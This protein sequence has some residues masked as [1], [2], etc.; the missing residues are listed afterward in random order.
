MAVFIRSVSAGSRLQLQ[1]VYLYLINSWNISMVVMFLLFSWM[2]LFW[3]KNSTSS[4][5]CVRVSRLFLKHTMSM[6]SDNDNKV[7]SSVQVLLAVRSLT[8]SPSA[9]YHLFCTSALV[10]C[11]IK[12]TYLLINEGLNSA[13]VDVF[14]AIGKAR[15]GFRITCSD[16]ADEYKLVFVAC[17]IEL[18]C[19]CNWCRDRYNRQLSTSR[20]RTNVSLR[21]FRYSDKLD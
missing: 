17:T 18:F 16:E 12:A 7:I 13:I 20:M 8:K 1:R 6:S 19:D 3:Q 21:R 10:T 9:I 14:V 11:W 5:L 4:Y 2:S 15:Q